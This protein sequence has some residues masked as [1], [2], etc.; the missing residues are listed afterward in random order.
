VI[1]TH[2]SATITSTQITRLPALPSSATPAPDATLALAM[3]LL[4]HMPSKLIVRDAQQGFSCLFPDG[5]AVLLIPR[6]SLFVV[7]W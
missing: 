5:G 1:V 3:K 4:C 2:S 6:S 7:H